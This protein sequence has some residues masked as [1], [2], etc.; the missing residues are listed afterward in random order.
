[1]IIDVFAM[2]SV[3]NRTRLL[4]RAARGERREL[5][6]DMTNVFVA[7]ANERVIDGA[8]RLAA[9]EFEGEELDTATGGDRP[10]ACASRSARS[11]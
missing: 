11:R 2:D 9:N 5:R 3:V 8:R 7:S 6:L 1:M 4:R 10:P